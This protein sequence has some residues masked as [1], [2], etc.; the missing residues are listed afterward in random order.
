MLKY[1]I[2]DVSEYFQIPKSTLRYWESEELIALNRN[3][4][5]SY[6]EYDTQSLVELSDMVF[7]RSLDVPVKQLRK[8]PDMTSLELDELL[9]KT[10]CKL[11][12]IIADLQNKKKKIASKRNMI[13][14]IKALENKQLI[15]S[16][17]DFRYVIPFDYA[18]PENWK[19]YLEDTSLFIMYVSFE[20]LSDIQFGI[21]TEEPTKHLLWES[22]FSQNMPEKTS[23]YKT[24]I[25][26]DIRDNNENN[27][28]QI[29]SSLQEKGLNPVYAIGRFLGFT[30]DDVRWGYYESW[31]Y[32]NTSE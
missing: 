13:H 6:R 4:N 5:N 16:M 17:P 8:L 25:K 28:N 18:S 10:D 3:E 32:C 26:L 12:N 15:Q 7:Y 30:Y 24:L 27:L 9:E 22:N 29:K 14:K 20:H 1:K 21:I 31:V 11:D 23:F 2:K 19:C